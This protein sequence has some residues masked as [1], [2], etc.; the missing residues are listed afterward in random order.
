MRYAVL[1][2]SGNTGRPVVERLLAQGKDVRAIA[3]TK[4]RLSGLAQQGAHIL[5]GS[6]ADAAFLSRALEG[7]TAVYAML[8]PDLTVPD[9]RTYYGGV[10]VSIITA[11][12]AAGV[13]HVVNLSSQ[14]AHLPANTGPIAGL[15][16]QER[17]LNALA[18]IHVM[19]LRPTFFM[20]NLLQ[21]IP[22]VQAG[23]MLSGP[24][25]GDLP[26][27]M[28][29]TRDIGVVAADHLLALDFQG[30]VVHDLLG[31]RNVT[32]NEVARILGAAVGK[33]DLT[34]T[35]VSYEAAHRGMIAAGISKGAARSFIE[36]YRAFNDGLIVPPARDA[37]NTTP[38]TIEE[39]S[40][41]F[42][43]RYK[44]GGG[45]KSRGT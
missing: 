28:I 37:A 27:A 1:G 15:Y 16:D 18:G 12:K 22:A 34:Y 44:E 42:A 9:V 32:L 31:P 45:M 36:M 24:L 38:T 40:A 11:L 10:G 25:R 39:F 41:V 13:T 14:G 33:P 30:H 23:G 20:E 5:A 35:Q 17:R 3:R 19:H 6:I 8:P 21:H 4:G 2:A 26:M 29:A 7:V 43:S